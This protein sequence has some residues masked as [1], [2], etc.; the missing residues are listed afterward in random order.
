ML[1]PSKVT[2]FKESVLADSMIIGHVLKQKQSCRVSD[3]FVE[4]NNR[5][6]MEVEAIMDGLVLLY[7]LRKLEINQE[8]ICYVD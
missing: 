4:C 5:Y 7:S 3:L 2:T 8:E 6:K 1:F